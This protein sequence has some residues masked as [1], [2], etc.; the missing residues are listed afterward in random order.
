MALSRLHR[1]SR[2]MPS[3]WLLL[4]LSAA[5]LQTPALAEIRALVIGIDD[6]RHGASLHGAVADATD[7]AT[8]L[9]TLGVTDLTIRL[10]QEANRDR[11]TQD[12]EELVA[13]ARSGDTLVLTFAGHGSQDQEHIPGSEEDGKDE[14]LLLGEF[15][16]HGKGTRERIIDDEL[17]QW[18]M[19][20]HDKGAEVLFVADACHSGTLTRGVDARANPPSY[21]YASYTITE[22]DLELDIPPDIGA[23][24]P[25]ELTNLTF[26]AAGQEY[27]QIP[28]VPLYDRNW[29]RVQRGALSWAFSRALEGQADTNSDGQLTRGEIYHFVRANVR[30]L[31]EARQTPNLLPATDTDHVVLPTAPPERVERFEPGEWPVIRVRVLG[32]DPDS[33]ARLTDRPGVTLVATAQADADLVLDLGTDQAIS[34]FGDVIAYDLTSAGLSSVIDKWRGLARLKLERLGDQLSM[35]VLPDDHTHRQGQQIGFE[36]NAIRLPYLVFFSLSGDGTVHFHYPRPGDTE[37]VAVNEPFGLDFEVTPP[38]G[39]DH[40]IAVT[41]DQPLPAL[42]RTL[43]SLDGSRAPDRA[44]AAVLRETRQGQRQ[45]GIQGLFTAP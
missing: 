35:R 21:R 7:I 13:R 44:V 37:T 42:V 11:L 6:Y 31:A 24:D 30:A 38:F 34:G 19:A 27:E 8:A 17:N 20:A 36:I 5:C 3:I 16:E 29:Q 2:T 26:L 25:E 23:A 43:A 32:D 12:W 28:E 4:G 14:V 33:A 1:R 22:D 18:F 41:S 39:A 15:T 9:R 10:N 40:I 45:L